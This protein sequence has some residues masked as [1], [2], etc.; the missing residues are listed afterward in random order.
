M[1]R[2]SWLIFAAGG[3][4][5]GASSLPGDAEPPAWTRSTGRDDY[6][7]TLGVRTNRFGGAYAAEQPI[8]VSIEVRN[9]GP[10]DAGSVDPSA[11]L[12][13]HLDAWVE[14]GGGRSYH[15]I[16][17]GI[18]NRLVIKKGET[19]AKVFDLRRVLPLDEPG[20]YR[21]TLGH[22]NRSITDLGDWTGSL[23]SPGCVVRIVA[24]AEAR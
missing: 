18:E 19:F 4:S 21:I 5:L 7:R 11:Q 2:T 22:E 3:L 12:F 16:P 15:S 6:R 1:K 24:P 23:W 9:F 13:P 20:E 10:K 14:A 17:L 8:P